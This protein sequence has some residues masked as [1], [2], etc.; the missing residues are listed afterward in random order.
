MISFEEQGILT[1]IKSALTGEK[2]PLPEEFNIEFALQIAKKHQIYGL[3]YYGAFNCGIDKKLPQMQ[4]LFI[5][6]YKNLVISEGQVYEIKN[7]VKAFDESEIDYMFLKGTLLKEMYPKKELRA[8]G[9]A[10]ILIKTEQ[11]DKIKPVMQ[12]LGFEEK[13]ESDHEL[14]WRKPQLLL[15][16]HK[17]LI[18]SYNKDYFA[19]FGDGWQ[20]GKPNP[21]FPHRF[22][23][24]D[25]DQMIYLF[26]HFAK[27][28]RDAGIGIR[29][30]VD[31]YVYKNAHP[32][33]NEEYIKEELEKLEIYEFYKNVLDTLDVWF[34]EEQGNEKTDYI[35][36]VIF[37]SGAF[38]DYR[39]SR[40][41]QTIKASATKKVNKN[42]KLR[43]MIQMTF[44]SKQ[45]MSFH[46]PILEKRGFSFLLPFCWVLRLFT[47]LLF[48][49]DRAKNFYKTM[50]S[51]SASDISDY[52]Q[53][54]RF[55]GLDF[56]FK[57]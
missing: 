27:H 48:K 13:T 31:L 38:G 53:T 23:M 25:E 20:L 16:L 33:L 40:I 55:V 18:P 56:N 50:N 32:H 9:D 4:E 45:T 17:R 39:K 54:L 22:E 2:L 52:E 8:M 42:R 7:I 1:L 3:I 30:V 41:S 34:G 37:G 57:E 11:Y 49:R 24:T 12:S 36:N 19:Y 15:E 21:D 6:V 43:R 47:V 14:I 51:F 29:H 35:T 44:P 28:Y 5:S 46:Y 10:D 26:T